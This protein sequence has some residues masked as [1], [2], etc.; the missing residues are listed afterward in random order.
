MGLYSDIFEQPA[1]L[2][3]ALETQYQVA[4][5]IARELRRRDLRY[6]FLAARGT[7]DHAGVYAQYVW[8]SLN[9]LPVAFAAPSLFTRYGDWPRLD[10]ALVVG[11]S[12]SGQ[13][14]DVVS[15]IAEGRR[16][17]AP[18]LAITNDP[19]S[20]LAQSAEFTLDILAGP[21]TAVAAT[22]TYTAELLAVAQM[23]VAMHETPGEHQADLFRIPEAVAAALAL[24]EP[25]RHA[26]EALG[27]AEKCIILGRGYNY[28][29]ALEWA[30]K[31]KELAYVMADPYAAPD[32]K[33]GP[34]ALVEPGFPVLAVAPAGAVAADVIELLRHLRDTLGAELLVISDD[35]AALA[36]G[37]M[38]LRLPAGVPEWLTPLVSIVPAQLYCYHL[39]RSKGLDTEAPRYLKKV[40]ETR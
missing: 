4:Q 6:V 18:T 1:V 9:R 22:K 23:A 24:D 39:T 11:I 3:R 21:E 33:H 7:S 17:G 26:A 40:T 15:V 19:A 31:L 25:A 36:A 30:L 29:T 27:S 34:I 35:E 13:S 32:F 28:A 16:Q 8:G 14:P 12:Q 37:Q 38:S 20:P 5:T 2:R 10:D